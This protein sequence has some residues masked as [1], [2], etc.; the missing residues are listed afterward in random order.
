MQ[1]VTSSFAPDSTNSADQN[2]MKVAIDDFR[3]LTHFGE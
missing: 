1:S 2:F 3:F